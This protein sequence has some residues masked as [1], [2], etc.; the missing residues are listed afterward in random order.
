M[1]PR[2]L[3]QKTQA[4]SGIAFFDF[5]GTITEKDS[6]LEIIKFRHGTF[7]FYTGM[8]VNSPLLVAMKAGVISNQKAKEIVLKWFFGKMTIDQFQQL[9]DEFA[10]TVIP[11]LIRPKAKSEIEKLKAS[12]YEVVIVSASAENWLRSWCKAEGLSLLGTILET[13]EGRIT[14][15]I[16]GNNCYGVEKVWRVKEKYDLTQYQN[17]LCY[18]DTKGD[19]PLLG[20]ATISF[21]KPFR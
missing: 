7:R 13:K 20:L 19:K 3:I 11:S 12:G 10:A 8:L 4:V 21:Y 6:L 5:D 18:G 15:N 14:G 16:Q 2:I 17:I 9:A 1:Y